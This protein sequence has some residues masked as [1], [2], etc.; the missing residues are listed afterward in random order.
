MTLLLT[1]SITA[2]VSDLVMISFYVFFSEANVSL[3]CT[4]GQAN[5]NWTAGRH[6]C[7]PSMYKESPDTRISS[8]VHTYPRAVVLA[9]A[10]HLRMKF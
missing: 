9:Y 6:T 4:T 8:E 3:Y 10:C 5:S 7:L 1:V 2:S